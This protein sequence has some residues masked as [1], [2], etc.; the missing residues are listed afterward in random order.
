MNIQG[1]NGPGLPGSGGSAEASVEKEAFLKLLVAQ[2]SNQDPMSPQGSESFMQ[3]LTQFSTL[4]QLMNLNS[5]VDTL[6]MGQLSNNNQEAVRFVDREILAR[7]N[8]L[9]LSVGGDAEMNFN[10]EEGAQRVEVK[11]LDE[12]G[13][14]I[15]SL[16]E[17]VRGSEHHLIW[18]GKDEEGHRMP[19]GRY[20]VQIQAFGAED[21]PR[22]V[23][24]LVRGRVTGVRFDR[25]YPEL[26][27]GDQRVQL[28]DLIE[29][30]NA[31]LEPEMLR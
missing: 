19:E 6:A 8:S 30:E 7:G 12:N 22:A 13:R 1:I 20:Q 26:M 16:E 11:I 3:Q 17:G 25:G 15:R 10:L 31:G 18:D 4:E 29:V 5:G 23:D 14:V 21:Q 2:I 9:E 24:M 28:R 27:L